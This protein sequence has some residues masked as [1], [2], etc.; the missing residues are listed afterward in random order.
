VV[1]F[2][3]ITYLPPQELEILLIFS[4]LFL[5]VNKC[6]VNGSVYQIFIIPYLV[7]LIL[8]CSIAG[9]IDSPLLFGSL[10]IRKRGSQ[11]FVFINAF[12]RYY[13]RRRIKVPEYSR[14]TPY[15]IDFFFLL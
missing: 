2:Y 9:S 11:K 5:A 1:N 13:S 6:D 4:L 3:Q 15:F 8:S 10:F 7:F 12:G 14:K